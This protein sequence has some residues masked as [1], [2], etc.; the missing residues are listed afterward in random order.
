MKVCEIFASI[1]GESSF[2]GYPCV[3][4]RLTG[5]NLR[6][7]YC[8]TAYAYNE[9]TDIEL[10]EILEKVKPYGI[11]LIEVTGGEPLLQKESYGLIERLLEEGF[12]VLLETNGSIS[13]ENVDQRVSVIL[14]IKTPSSSMSNRMFMKNLDLVSKKDD[15][16]FVL[17]SR[18]DYEWVKDV[19]EKHGFSERTNI[20]L[21]PV[22][23][24]LDPAMLARWM[25]KDGIQARLNLQLHRYIFG[26]NRRGV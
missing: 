15:V 22:F 14:D 18:E 20:L 25:V 1:Q 19:M 9:G 3:F 16:K 26:S 13:V 10:S 5:C 4:V 24:S 8:D 11:K 21:S 12:Q 7:S 2:A 23:G 17:G 6:C